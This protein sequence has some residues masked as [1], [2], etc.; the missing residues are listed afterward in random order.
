MN[1]NCKKIDKEKSFKSGIE[2]IF[3][4]PELMSSEIDAFMYFLHKRYSEK[5]TRADVPNIFSFV[6]TDLEVVFKEVKHIKLS[7]D[8]S[9]RTL[10][11][12]TPLVP[13]KDEEN[14]RLFLLNYFSNSIKNNQ[15]SAT[16]DLFKLLK[17]PAKQTLLK[18]Y[19]DHKKKDIK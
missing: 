6:I 8:Y 16:I 5:N 11:I 3:D 7:C 15:L 2:E 9:Q 17:D 1:M 14:R 18:E 4:S 10:S 19:K 12:L 13:E